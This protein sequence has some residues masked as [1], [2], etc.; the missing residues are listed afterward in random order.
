VLVY[1][2]HSETVDSA[3]WL[4]ELRETLA[5][6]GTGFDRH[7]ELVS[8]LIR[9]GRLEQ[10]LADTGWPEAEALNRFTYELARRVVRSWDSGF[11]EIGEVPAV[12]E[13]D[14]RGEVELRL[15]EGFA[16]YA[17]YPESY[18]DAA[19]KLRLCG[20]PRVIGIRS[21]G[22]TLGA[23]VAAA[24]EAQPPVTVRPFGEPFE[25]QVELP[26]EILDAKAHY[27]IVDEGPGQSGSSFG[28]VADWLEERGVPLERIA[29]L[30]SHGGDPGPRASEAHRERWNKVQRVPA[31][32]DRSWLA[33]RFGP[34]E[35]LEIGERL[36]FRCMAGGE[37]LLLKFAGLGG[38][39]ERK[40]GI[41]RALHAAGFTPEPLG[42]VHGFL[43]ERWCD[44][45]PLHPGDKPI[46]EIGRYLGARARLLPAGD[47]SGASVD[48]LLTMCRRNLSL[49]GV[50]LGRSWDLAALRLERVR[51]DNRLD[52]PKWLRAERG[53]LVKCDALDHHQGHDL[54]GCQDLAWDVAGA[55]VE[56]GLSSAETD[57]LIAAT[58][59]AVDGDLLD[60]CLVAYC[61]F[62]LGEASLAGDGSTAHNYRRRVELLLHE[63]S[64]CPESA[65]ILV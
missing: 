28:A 35:Q 5:A 36:K 65:P 23:V 30:P 46:D 33:Q 18:I 21:I 49:C 60:F 56:F 59:K 32:F 48:Q 38:I 44:G 3:Q 57:Q 17:V 43:V 55:A 58:G 26:P 37:A 63:N 42:L 52:D 51:T 1:G 62:R 47:A 41:A 10:G 13:I 8:A 6:S 64:C 39:G 4:G 27:V 45:E 24:L 50:D 53:R 15:P 22:T 40:L 12:P 25:R 29:F 54:I 9:A 2:D 16:F 20:P 11:G 19:R 61:C 14:S 34:L 7:A 31:A